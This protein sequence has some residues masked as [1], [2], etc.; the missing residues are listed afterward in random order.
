MSELK[1]FYDVIIIGAGVSGGALANRPAESGRNI[2]IVERGPRL[3]REDD[4]WSVDAVF[5]E[6]KYATK[7]EWRDKNGQSF[8]PS[9]YYYVGGNSK[10]FGAATLRFRR[11][12]FEDLQHEGGVAGFL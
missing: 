9:T 3:P 12:D 2:L 8:N 11:E 4:N 5:H 6:K 7:E 1:T 10:F